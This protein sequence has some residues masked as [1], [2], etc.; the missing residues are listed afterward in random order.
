MSIDGGDPYQPADQYGEFE[1]QAINYNNVGNSAVDSFTDLEPIEVRGGLDPN[2]MAE[3]VGF[4]ANHSYEGTGT[5]EYGLGINMADDQFVEQANVNNTAIAREDSEVRIVNYSEQGI[6]DFF[7][8]DGGQST[9]ESDMFNFRA[10]L[11][12]GPFIDANDDLTL[13]VENTADNTDVHYVLYWDVFELPEGRSRF[14]L[15]QQ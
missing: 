8:S 3:L 15:P 14:S 5:I 2:E 9:R 10:E 1:A 4:R 12:T 11:G 7:K 6:I 13:H